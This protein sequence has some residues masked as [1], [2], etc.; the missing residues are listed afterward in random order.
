[1][2]RVPDR[3]SPARRRARPPDAARARPPDRR[4]GG[5]RRT[6]AVGVPWLG[7]TC[8]ECVYCASG[9]ENLCERARFTGRDIDGG[10][11]E[12]AVADERFCFP[13]PD[14]YPDVQA[15]PLLCAGLIGFR[16]LRMAGD[17]AVSGSTASARRRTSSAQVAVAGPARVRLHA[18]AT[19]R[20]RPCARARRRLGGRLGPRP[21]SRSTPRSSSPRRARWS[22]ALAAIGQGGAV[23]CAGIHMSDIPRS[24][25]G[26]SGGSAR[27]F[28]REPDPGGRPRVPRARPARAGPHARHLVR[29]RPRPGE[30]LADLRSGR[31]VGAAVVEP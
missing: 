27:P 11:A 8:G 7:W 31:V 4:H 15:A 17:A 18:R 2:R 14:G 9:R 6:A 12:Y 26:C 29:P 21:P 19:T 22:R 1:M 23:I 16:A 30:A 10:F 20:R 24:P 28:G 3:P 5:R 25:T 13:I